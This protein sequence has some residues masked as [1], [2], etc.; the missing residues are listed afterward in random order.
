MEDIALAVT[1][2]LVI[3]LVQQKQ[4]VHYYILFVQRPLGDILRQEDIQ[5]FKWIAFII[6]DFRL[7]RGN[8]LQP[9]L[10]VIGFRGI[11]YFR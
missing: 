1:P 5:H 6:D 2:V 7:T 8:N 9:G 10:K 4:L 3:L 11:L